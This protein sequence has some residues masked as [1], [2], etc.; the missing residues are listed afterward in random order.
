MDLTRLHP[1]GSVKSINNYPTDD[2]E[3]N[4]TDEFLDALNVIK[5]T[6][7][8]FAVYQYNG[9]KSTLTKFEKLIPKLMKKFAQEH[10]LELYQSVEDGTTGNHNWPEALNAI[11][12]DFTKYVCKFFKWNKLIPTRG[13]VNVGSFGNERKIRSYNLQAEDIPTLDVWREQQIVIMNKQF[14]N[15]NEIPIWQKSI[16]TRNY[17]RNIFETNSKD[18]IVRGNPVPSIS[19]VVEK[20]HSSEW[21]G[22]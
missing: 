4:L 12:Y 10:N 1:F 20:W 16:H 14:R 7:D 15:N 13:F 18:C 6:K 8:I 2:P 5:L 17:D 21:F 22:L 11:N 3:V 19:P 9:G